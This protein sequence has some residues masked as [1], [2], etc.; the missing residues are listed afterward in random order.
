MNL[1]DYQIECLNELVA[2]LEQ[3]AVDG[4]QKAFQGIVGR[5]YHSVA[6]FSPEMPYVCLKVPT[7]GGKTLIAA[8]AVGRVAA[9]HMENRFANRV[10]A[11]ADRGDCG[12][13]AESADRFPSVPRCIGEF[14]SRAG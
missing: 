9:A 3:A 5:G 12:S 2:Y 8:H 1:H 10:V 6:G 13:D 7:G 14:V 4:A 11:R